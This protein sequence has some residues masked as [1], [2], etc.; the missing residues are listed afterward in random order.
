MLTQ[1]VIEAIAKVKEL[2]ISDITAEST[3]VELGVDSLDAIEILFELEEQYDIN[4]PTDQLQGLEKVQDVVDGVQMV[5]DM[6]AKEAAGA[7]DD[8]DASDAQAKA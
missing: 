2:P 1:K 8:G 3:F 6:K 4:V 5:L 7:S